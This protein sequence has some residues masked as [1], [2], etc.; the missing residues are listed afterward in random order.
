LFLVQS[1]IFSLTQFVAAFYKLFFS[2]KYPKI[3]RERR[4]TEEWFLPFSVSGALRRGE[5][6]P[7]NLLGAML[8]R[9]CWN[10][11]ADNK[12]D[13]SDSEE[14]EQVIEQLSRNYKE[15]RLS[16]FLQG[17]TY[18]YPIPENPKSEEQK[19]DLPAP[20][21]TKSKQ[22]HSTGKQCFSASKKTRIE[23]PTINDTCE[24]IG[25]V[26]KERKRKLSNQEDTTSRLSKVRTCRLCE[27]KLLL[28]EQDVQQHIKSKVKYLFED[29]TRIF[30]YF[31]IHTYI[32]ICIFIFITET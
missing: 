23:S 29:N 26:F 28:N 8:K 6:T 27:D 4:P 13:S 18:E 30:I 2:D 11:I 14:D 21:R 5:K 9:L 1:A 32:Y 20:T 17:E 31:C 25:I 16:L 7:Q 24:P 19:E 12:E 15:E 22:R 10:D 3:Y